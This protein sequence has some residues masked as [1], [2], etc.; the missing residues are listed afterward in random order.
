MVGKIAQIRHSCREPDQLLV[1]CFIWH[2]V[3][4]NVFPRQ[5]HMTISFGLMVVLDQREVTKEECELL[6]PVALAFSAISINCF[7]SV[8]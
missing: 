7:S 8:L 3:S 4:F 6:S 5:A 2:V 1:F